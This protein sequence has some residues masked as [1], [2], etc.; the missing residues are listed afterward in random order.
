MHKPGPRRLTLY[1]RQACGLC[2]DMHWQLLQLA[3]ELDI[4]VDWVE[5]DSDTEL[6]DEFSTRIPVLMAEDTE[7]CHHILDTVALNAYLDIKPG[8]R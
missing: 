3:E 4:R 1:G 6:V 2:Q 7:I 8:P 5:I